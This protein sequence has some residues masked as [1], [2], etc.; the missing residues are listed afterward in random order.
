MLR[1]TGKHRTDI[2]TEDIVRM[3]VDEK[4][5]TPKIAKLFDCST[6][7][8]RERLVKAG[9]K[10]RKIGAIPKPFIYHTSG[11]KMLLRPE[12]PNST[13]YGYVMEHRLIMEEQ[14]GRYLTKDENIHHKNG[15]RDDNR[16]ENLELW[17]VMQPKGQRV[18]DLLAWAHEL[19]E[20]YEDD[21]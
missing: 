11:Y 3:Y 4:L 14:L 7:L 9:V 8:V 10:L 6:V 15:Q 12:H 16:P 5:S 19:I 1:P 17:L 18:E 21:S 20:R 2:K 13:N